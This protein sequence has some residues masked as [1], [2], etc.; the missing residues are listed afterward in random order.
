[1]KRGSSARFLSSC[2]PSSCSSFPRVVYPR[3]RVISRSFSLL[4]IV[5]LLVLPLVLFLVSP[6]L[7]RLLLASPPSSSCRGVSNLS[8]D[9]RRGWRSHPTESLGCWGV[10]PFARS[11][12]YRPSSRFSPPRRLTTLPPCRLYPS[13]LV[14]ALRRWVMPFVV[15]L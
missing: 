6:F 4:S 13:S 15:G 8:V 14:Y 5:L 7:L 1:M 9:R 2:C 11:S 10:A 3:L 12:S